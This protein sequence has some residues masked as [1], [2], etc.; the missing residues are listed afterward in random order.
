MNLFKSYLFIFTALIPLIYRSQNPSFNFQK[1]GSEEG[2]NNANIFNIEQHKNG[3]MYFTTQNGIFYYDGYSFNKLEIDSL[4]SNALLSVSIKNDDELYLSINNEG[5]AGYN[6]IKGEYKLLPEFKVND[7]NADNFIITEKYAYLLTS[8]IKLL[9]I[10]RSTGKLIPDELKQKNKMNVAYCLYKTKDGRILIG[11]SDGLY[12]IQGSHQVR[13]PV[14]QQLTVNSLTQNREGKILAGAGGK[15]YLLNGNSIEQEIA[16]VYNT[17]S[18]TFLPDGERSIDKIIADDYGRIWFTSSPDENLYLYKNKTVYNIFEALGIPPTLINCVFKDARENIWIGTI[19]DG[20]YYIQNPFFST[21]NFSY[22]NKNLNVNQ[23]YYKGNLLVAATSNGLY[24]LNVTNNQTKTLSQPDETLLESINSITQFKNVLYYTK[25]SELDI[26]P[27]IFF[28]SKNTYKFKPIIARQFYP[29]DSTKS[30]LADWFANILL[31]NLDGSKV[32]DTL[33]SFTDYRMQVNAILKHNSILYLATN[34]GLIEYDFKTKKYRNLVRN[35]LNFNINDVALVNNKIYAAHEAG[36]TDVSERKLI[37]QVGNFRLNSVKKI[38]QYNDE[39]WLATLDGVFICDQ[40]MVPHKTLNKSNGLLSNSVNDISFN[41]EMVS[42]ATARGVSSTEYRNIVKFNA[43]LNP[44]TINKI[45]C[46]NKQFLPV[47]SLYTFKSDEENLSISFYSPFYNK[48]NKQFFRWRTDKG[49]WKNIN[50]TSFELNLSGGTHEIEISASADDIVWSDN[51]IIKIVKEE[52]ITEKQSLYWLI[53]LGGLT[54]II[55]ISSIWIRRVKIKARKRLQDEQQV[56]LLKHQAMNALLSPHFI[57][58]S[59]TSIQNYINTNNSLK[60]SEYLAKFSRLI[61]MIIEKAAQSEITLHDELARLTYYLELE[62]ERF[63]NKFD[64]QIKLDPEIDTQNVSIPNMII[65]PHVENCIIHGI[66][67]THQHGTLTVS[68]KKG[69]KGKLLITIEDDG[70]GLIKAR[71][72]AKAGHKS[73]GTSTIK[74]ILEINSKISGKKQNVTMVDKS[75]FQPPQNGTL[76]S[77]ELE[78]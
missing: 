67:P 65:Q 14:L 70:I 64:Y 26:S 75:T 2:L 44:V 57:F 19:N 54:I 33:I 11:R 38:R 74:N 72:H 36:I 22:N 51:T 66:L 7:N 48:P 50:N 53:T 1:L 60:A 43:K 78:L 32:L 47:N 55:L 5:I 35:E 58:N 34:K 37:Q 73:L 42:I 3:L 6:L 15:I 27:T 62:K 68:F 30:V 77:I 31:C 71:D 56:N 61:R 76:I 16:P 20:V 9:T 46:N 40:N 10:D 24:G 12:E 4:K 21:I 49:E 29:I 25:R 17:K 13:L 45:I 23:V 8:G 39:V 59:L 41:G 18:H 63:K 28:D 52:K 69:T